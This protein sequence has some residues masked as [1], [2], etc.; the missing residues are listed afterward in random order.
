M[1]IYF[2]FPLTRCNGGG[3]FFV[4]QHPRG[5]RG[6]KRAGY[7]QLRGA[8]VSGNLADCLCFG[9]IQGAEG[10]KRWVMTDAAAE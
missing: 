7:V 9:I 4:K 10:E 8:K 1:L 2:T 3:L 5:L 6:T